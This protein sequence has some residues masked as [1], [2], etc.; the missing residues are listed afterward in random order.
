MF[1]K[2]LTLKGSSLMNMVNNQNNEPTQVK[3]RLDRSILSAQGQVGDT[4]R[5]HTH[6]FIHSWLSLG[7]AR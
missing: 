7:F 6:T 5:T 1:A 4:A 2:E 3:G